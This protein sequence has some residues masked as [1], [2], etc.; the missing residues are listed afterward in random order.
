MLR[1]VRLKDSN[2]NHR[3]SNIPGCNGNMT[4]QLCHRQENRDGLASRAVV[5][6]QYA[7][8][9]VL[10]KAQPTSESRGATP[11]DRHLCIR[12]SEGCLFVPCLEAMLRRLSLQCRYPLRTA[13]G[14]TLKSATITCT[15]RTSS[16]LYARK[17]AVQR[18]GEMPSTRDPLS[19]R[20]SKL[21][22]RTGDGS[23]TLR[24][25]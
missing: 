7:Q 18:H 23:V 5:T 20:T 14:G 4:K 15:A 2:H 19:R 11:A 21:C 24:A 17:G 25:Y 10:Q 13:R 6:A 16:P 8:G 3:N 1:W 9:R 12:V 22:T